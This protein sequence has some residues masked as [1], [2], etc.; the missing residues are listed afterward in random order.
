[1]QPSIY[2]SSLKIK[3]NEY[4]NYDLFE[5]QKHSIKKMLNKEINKSKIHFNTN[6]EILEE[7]DIFIDLYKRKYY[8]K[9][10]SVNYISWES[11]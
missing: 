4:I 1:M 6:D 9:R 5:Y 10:Y 11:V 8:K 2:N 7:G 3:E